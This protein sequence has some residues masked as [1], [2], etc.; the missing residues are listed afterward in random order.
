VTS[1]P[2][3]PGRA[4]ASAEVR[5]RK[6]RGQNFLAQPALAARIVSALEI[7]PN[8]TV[9]EIGPGLGILSELL[10]L[11]PLRH[12]DLIEVDPR[13]AARLAARFADDARVE[14]HHCDFLTTNLRDLAAGSQLRVIGNLPFNIASAILERL[15][16]FHKIITRMVLMFQREVA[17]RI[18]ARAGSRPYG[19]LS[20]YTALYWKVEAYFRVPAGNFH[21]RPKVDAEVLTLTP[22]PA[23]FAPHEEKAVLATVRA[24]FSAP[25]KTVR[26]SLAGGLGIEGSAAEAALKQ[27]AID[28]MV[29]PAA[30]VDTDFVRLARVLEA[31]GSREGLGRRRGFDDA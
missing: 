8:D 31:R 21:P 28:P 18:R 26:N 12:L 20:V 29:R 6:S 11:Q 19:A 17:E 24:V 10:A 13:L 4:L 7:Q 2:L 9:V 3:S 14:V 1:F 23:P 27:A 25:R 16:D 22:R 15:D 30:L 5:P